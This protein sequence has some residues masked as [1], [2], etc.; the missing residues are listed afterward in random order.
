MSSVVNKSSTRFVPKAAGRGP[1]RG[2]PRRLSSLNTSFNASAPQGESL[3]SSTPE[4]SRPVIP[5]PD[6]VDPNAIEDED[7]PP[8]RPRVSFAVEEPDATEYPKEVH[9]D[10]DGT[11]LSFSDTSLAR[12]NSRRLSSSRGR[13][14]AELSISFKHAE[15]PGG[16]VRDA[17]SAV[18]SATGRDTERKAHSVQRDSEQ[19]LII[20]PEDLPLL[21]RQP[22]EIIEDTGEKDENGEPI[23]RKVQRVINVET[24]T[25]AELCQDIPVG[26]QNEDFDAY[27][28]ARMSRKRYRAQI[29]KAKQ[30]FRG[31]YDPKRPEEREELENL[32]LDWRAERDER[33]GK[34]KEEAQERLQAMDAEQ[35]AQQDAAVPQLE[36]N[37]DGTIQL[38]TSQIDRHEHNMA[39]SEN[40]KET[41]ELKKYANVINSY[42]FSSKER[43][44][45]WSAEETDIFYQALS[46]WG[47]DFNLIAHMFP[48]RSRHQIKTKFKYEERR[49]PALVQMYLVHRRRVNAQ[50]Y[51]RISGVGIQ[52]IQ[53]F[54][55]DLKRVREEH[56]RQ[57]SET[58]TMKRRAQ[59]EDKR[60]QH[61]SQPRVSSVK[62]KSASTDSS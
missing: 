59:E 26:Q 30:M 8:K 62:V 56:E 32:Y 57:M 34:V 14:Q 21:K 35:K 51:E 18:S 55:E 17:S 24:F 3:Q 25:M 12:P 47:T 40:R 58:E 60:R 5:T 46:A 19:N 11:G 7:N 45:R 38:R 50:D 43:P 54:E 20:E 6:Q 13:E 44:E 52:D 28:E 27:E 41:V 37:A 29:L 15:Y 2:V 9:D 22:Q 4:T 53:S 42:S 10:T 48:N 49:N 61:E 33:F 16:G 23:T 36:R 39:N 31:K 1:G